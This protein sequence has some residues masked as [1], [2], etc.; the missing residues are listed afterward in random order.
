M[1]PSKKK[2]CHPAGRQPAGD[3]G[4][5]FA[6]G[7][8][9]AI[10]LRAAQAAAE[11]LFGAGELFAAVVAGNSEAARLL[12]DAGADPSSTHSNGVV[13]MTPLM[14]AANC[15]QLEVLRLLLRRGAA[16]DAVQPVS[17]W[18]AF[19]FA[20]MKNKP[21]CAEAL[22]RFGCDVGIKSES[23]KTGREMAE[24]ASHTAV[25]GR[26]RAV[27]AEQLRAAQA[28]AV[29]L[30][31]PAPVPGVPGAQGAAE[32]RARVG[33]RGGCARLA[34]GG[35]RAQRL[36]LARDGAR[37][38]DGRVQA[39]C[40]AGQVCRTAD[41]APAHAAR[42]HPC[43]VREQRRWRWKSRW[44][45][46]RRRRR[47]GANRRG[48][49]PGARRATARLAR[50]PTA[51]AHNARPAPGGRTAAPGRV[52]TLQRAAAHTCRRHRAHIARRALAGVKLKDFCNFWG[53]CI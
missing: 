29:L 46:R 40:D 44:K 47:R 4:E 16:A 8:N 42:R 14:I 18:T 17:G 1:P 35:L 9:I 41:G 43:R 6:A 11:E 21:D 49:R 5:E 7:Y 13:V 33:V 28:A 34:F 53:V 38:L 51:D 25:V 50:Q 2:R 10:Q 20:C 27:V 36:P 39:A 30:P 37:A 15:G 22:I 48:T 23:G 52:S 31:E 12:L 26:L 45:T 19:H 24:S 32:P 3:G